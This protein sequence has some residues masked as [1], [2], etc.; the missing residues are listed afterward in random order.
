MHLLRDS[1]R[2]V[3]VRLHDVN[4]GGYGLCHGAPEATVAG[5]GVEGK[6]EGGE[7]FTFVTKAQ[8]VVELV[9]VG[10]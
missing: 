3:G 6:G 2:E 8:L 5:I 1:R 10:G 4:Q 7:A 9:A